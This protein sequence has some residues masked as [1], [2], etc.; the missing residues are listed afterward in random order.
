MDA[1]DLN[2]SNADSIAPQLIPVARSDRWQVYHR[3]QELE[4]SCRC[5]TDGRLEITTP[6]FATQVQVWSILY[7]LH[8]SRS[9]LIHLLE[10][11]WS[12]SA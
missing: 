2:S 12:T 6:S 9:Q 5:L 4:I 10:R 3:L 8:A 7:Q 11:S 1:L